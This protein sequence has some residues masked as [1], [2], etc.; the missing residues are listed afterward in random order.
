MKNKTPSTQQINDAYALAKNLYSKWNIDTDAAIEK[1][2]NIPVSAHC[3]QGDD[4]RGLESPDEALSGGIMATGN[5]P[6][7]ARDGD[8]LRADLLKALSLV[9]GKKRANIHAFYCETDGV[10]VERDELKPEHFAKWMTWSKE[11]NIA[12]D[13][14]PTYFSHSKAASGFTLSNADDE[15][16]QYW[17]RHGIACRKI[18][19]AFAENQGESC[20]INFWIPDGAKDSPADRWAPRA[21]LKDSYDKIFDSA[22]GVDTSKCIDAVECKL[23]GIGSEDYVVGS[24]EFYLS[25]SMKN[26]CIP[27][28][29]MGHFHPT[30]TIHDKLSSVLQ[31]KEK[32][33]MHVS[34]PIRWDSDHIVIFNDDVKNV[35]LELVRGNAIDKAYIALDFFDA[36]VN[37]IGAWTIGLRASQKALLYAVLDPSDLLKELELAG[38]GAGK[39]AVMEEMKTM[40]FGAVWDYYCTLQ[41]VPVGAGWIDDMRDY[42]KNVTSKRM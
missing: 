31:F 34:R 13:F 29:D 21:R 19:Q 20:V 17:I 7:V 38:D 41:N 14:N 4:V 26:D 16:R 36:S 5:Y 25:Y 15:I 23:F 33:L 6:G 28:L 39:L 35:F 2:K 11:N 30:E 9:P 22:H 42:E 18:A 37:R 40:P 8:E 32:V 12:L 24:H 3:W 27:C 1:L 10:K